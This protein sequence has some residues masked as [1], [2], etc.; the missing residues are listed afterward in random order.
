MAED[1]TVVDQNGALLSKSADDPDSILSDSQLEH[2][3]R[4]ESIYRSRIMSLVTPIVGPGNVSAQVNLDMD[5]TRNETTEEIVDP[6]GTA[7]RSK[8]TTL[9]ISTDLPARGIPGAVSNTPPTQA[10]LS[11]SPAENTGDDRIRTQSSS[12]IE[13]FEVSRT[14]STTQK[15]S[16]TII[17]ITA[18]VLLRENVS[19]NP[20]TGIEEGQ[21]L[22]PEKIAEIEKLVSGAIGISAERGDTLT[23]SSSP[24]VSTLEGVDKAVS[25]T[26]LTLPTSDLV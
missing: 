4:L 6:K 10:E 2:R 15:P 5:F 7:T 17:K 26:H 20:E 18:A 12:D 1:V 24:F 14:I 22:A 9:D 3:M 23:V 8:Q 16:N 21:P 13:N 25:Y 11:T 19:I